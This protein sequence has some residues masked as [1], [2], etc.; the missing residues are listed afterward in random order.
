[1][2]TNWMK[3]FEPSYIAELQAWAQEIKTGVVNPDFATAEDALIANE[4]AALGV[5]SVSK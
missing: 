3:K 4:S 5:A 2:D 1:M